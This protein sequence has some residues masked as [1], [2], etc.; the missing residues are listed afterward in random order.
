[1]SIFFKKF[2]DFS[3]KQ[4]TSSIELFSSNI[5]DSLDIFKSFSFE[6]NQDK[7][8]KNIQENLKKIR[9]ITKRNIDFTLD[10]SQQY[11][12]FIKNNIF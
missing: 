5:A 12:S 2:Q 11:N 10:A 9:T 1:M 8:N 7:I 6:N 3:E 4:L